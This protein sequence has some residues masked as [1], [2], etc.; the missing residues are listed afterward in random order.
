METMIAS[1]EHQCGEP[2]VAGSMSENHAHMSKKTAHHDEQLSAQSASESSKCASC[3]DKQCCCDNGSC[4]CVTLYS[5]FVPSGTVFD[6]SDNMMST[7]IPF[8]KVYHI[9][10]VPVFFL[11]PPI[12]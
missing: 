9:S 3:M 6:F 1:Q 2:E 7:S 11:R 8:M 10:P 5:M 12:S 4:A